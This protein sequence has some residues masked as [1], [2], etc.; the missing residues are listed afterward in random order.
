MI[1]SSAEIAEILKRR[2]DKSKDE[3]R[4]EWRVLS[5][6][7]PRGR[8]DLFISTPERVWQLKIEQTGNNEAIGFGLDVGKPDED[9]KKLF[10]HG[11]PVPFGLVSPQVKNN[12]AI[13]MAGIQL[14]SSD[15]AY[16]LCNEYV[17]NKQAE[18]DERLD[19]EIERMKSNPLLRHRYREQK[20][21]ERMS[22]L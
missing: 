8:Y 16:K 6:R 7:N 4:N 20:E 21:R 15:S 14:Y 5:G 13:V 9:I 1:K 11:A 22:Y 2:W 19:R 3:D 18:L 17:S 10:G 12:L